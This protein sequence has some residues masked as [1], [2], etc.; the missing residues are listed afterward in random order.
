MEKLQIEQVNFD[1]NTENTENALENG[2][3]MTISEF[4]AGVSSGLFTDYDGYGHLATETEE[5][6]VI[7]YPSIVSSIDYTVFTHVVWYNK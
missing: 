1:I 4:L 6:D 7:I 5:S 3:A 2:L